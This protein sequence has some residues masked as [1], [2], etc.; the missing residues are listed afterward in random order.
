MRDFQHPYEHDERDELET[1]QPGPPIDPLDSR[2]SEGDAGLDDQP[3]LD[4][5]ARYDDEADD[6]TAASGSGGE[7][8]FMPRP[9]EELLPRE[10]PISDLPGAQRETLLQS[11]ADADLNMPG[12]VDIEDLD[13]HSL[14]LT[15][16][17]EDAQ[18][19]PLEE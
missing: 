17:P 4:S 12:E 7:A 14:D 15:D 1:L 13:S 6:R 16:L 9:A 10:I 5:A 8:G 11:P 18:L 2:T 3:W 19:N